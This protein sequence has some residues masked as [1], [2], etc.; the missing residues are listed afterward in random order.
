MIAYDEYAGEKH[1]VEEFISF[2]RKKPI[3]IHGEERR[4]FVWG[5]EIWLPEGGKNKGPG[6]L[7]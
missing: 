6:G 1:L 7:I 5:Y 2:S 3:K 4:F